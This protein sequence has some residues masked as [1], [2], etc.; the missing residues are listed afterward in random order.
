VHAQCPSLFLHS[1][2]R[3]NGSSWVASMLD[4]RVDALHGSVGPAQLSGQGHL[5]NGYQQQTGFI[6]A[7]GMFGSITFCASP[8]VGSLLEGTVLWG[9]AEL[10]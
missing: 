1:F 3:M 6:R 2:V 10:F 7:P 8:L 9:A 5:R 4:D